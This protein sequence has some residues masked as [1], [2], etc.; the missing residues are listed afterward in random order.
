MILLFSVFSAVLCVVIW[1][2]LVINGTT[3]HLAALFLEKKEIFVRWDSFDVKMS[4]A[5]FLRKK[6]DLSASGL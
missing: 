5:S 6:F 4:S 2:E 3:L 1:P